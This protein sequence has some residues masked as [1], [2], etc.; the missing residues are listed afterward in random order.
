LE[1]LARRSFGDHDAYRSRRTAFLGVVEL[2][3]LVVGA[4]PVDL[5]WV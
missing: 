1:L 3:E 2:L 4:A 5:A